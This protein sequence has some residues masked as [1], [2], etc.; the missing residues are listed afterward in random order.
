MKKE[1][2]RFQVISELIEE[3]IRMEQDLNSLVTKSEREQL[4]FNIGYNTL[5]IIRLRGGYDEALN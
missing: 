5:R 4:E 1:K 3:N 2:C